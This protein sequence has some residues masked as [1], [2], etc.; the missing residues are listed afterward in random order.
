MTTVKEFKSNREIV[1]SITGMFRGSGTAAGKLS[2]RS[3]KKHNQ[4]GTL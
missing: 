2:R 3:K 4:E 1:N